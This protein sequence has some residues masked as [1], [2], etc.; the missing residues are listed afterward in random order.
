MIQ[1]NS[2]LETRK[3]DPTDPLGN[4]TGSN[5]TNQVSNKNPKEI[6]PIKEE[7]NENSGEYTSRSNGP[8][9]VGF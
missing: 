1:I 6:K 4:Q 7:I 8:S 2:P 9:V 3:K 5:P